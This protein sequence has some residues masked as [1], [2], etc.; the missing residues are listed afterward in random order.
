[1]IELTAREFMCGA[2]GLAIGHGMNNNIPMEEIMK[3]LHKTAER[4]LISKEDVDAI[5]TEL[6]KEFAKDSRV[7]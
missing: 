6:D 4:Y 5:M 1:M 7:K 2:I 3:V